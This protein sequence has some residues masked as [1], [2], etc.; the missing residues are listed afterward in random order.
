MVFR[1]ATHHSV[2]L[3]RYQVYMK[4]LRELAA[5][6]TGSFRLWFE[7]FVVPCRLIA[8]MLGG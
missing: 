2:Q 8:W 6:S 5:C 1:D 7:R 3:Q 4:G